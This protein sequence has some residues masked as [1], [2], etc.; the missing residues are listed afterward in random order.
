MNANR[1]I[2]Y[3]VAATL[4]ILIISSAVDLYNDVRQVNNEAKLARG[5]GTIDLNG[6][7]FA[8]TVGDGNFLTLE[9][10]NHEGY[11][12]GKDRS[13]G[14]RCCFYH[15]FQQYHCLDQQYSCLGDPKR[16]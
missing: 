11:L 9:N 2:Y 4:M 1:V 5:K 16:T 7:D 8:I 12:P 6:T 15:R 14:R 3:L 10:R 13:E